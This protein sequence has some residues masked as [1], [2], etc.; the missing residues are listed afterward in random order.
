MSE[1]LL[2]E[3]VKQGGFALLCAAMF[4]LYRH[5]SKAWAAKQTETAAAFMGFG[6]RTATALTQ[7][8]EALRRQSAVLERIEAHLGENHMCPV[9]QVTTELLRE[10][11]TD[12]GGR[13]RMDGIM[14]AA[15]VRAARGGSGTEEPHEG[16]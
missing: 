12:E 1:S 3:L 16:K 11:R 7:V 5:D 10:S 6:E 13:R 2:V 15:L 4:W 14:R 9:T 8:S